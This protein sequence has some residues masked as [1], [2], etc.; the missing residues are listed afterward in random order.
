MEPVHVPRTQFDIVLE[1]ENVVVVVGGVPGLECSWER[2]MQRSD[3]LAEDE[4][5]CGPFSEQF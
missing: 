3:L 5:I 2:G 1:G 4:T